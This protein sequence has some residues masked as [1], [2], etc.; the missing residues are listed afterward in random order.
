MIVE[1]HRPL[2]IYEEMRTESVEMN[3]HLS[4][5]CCS[6]SHSIVPSLSQVMEREYASQVTGA[7]PMLR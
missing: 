2:E 5:L 4:M 6:N 1:E 3:A 7:R